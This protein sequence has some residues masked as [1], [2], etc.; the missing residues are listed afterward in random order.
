[1]HGDAERI[2]IFPAAVLG[3]G[4]RG[5]RDGPESG[6]RSPAGRQAARVGVSAQPSQW[7]RWGRRMSCSNGISA[8]HRRQVP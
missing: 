2:T 5:E 8:P 6:R 3:T 1:M 4:A 7:R